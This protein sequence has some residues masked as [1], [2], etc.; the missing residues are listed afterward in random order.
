MPI[1]RKRTPKKDRLKKKSEEASRTESSNTPTKEE[2]GPDPTDDAPAEEADTPHSDTCMI[3]DPPKLEAT[4]K[5]RKVTKDPAPPKRT[6]RKATTATPEP[7]SPPETA[8]RTK[9]TSKKASPKK[10]KASPRKRSKPA[11]KSC[12]RHETTTA[13]D[14]DVEEESPAKSQMSNKYPSDELLPDEDGSD[15]DADKELTTNMNTT[16]TANPAGTIPPATFAFRQR[17]YAQ[18]TETAPLCYEGVVR[19][20]MYGVQ[21][22]RQLQLST[23]MTPEEIQNAL[24]HQDESEEKTWWYFIHYNGWNVKWDRWVEEQ[25]LYEVTESTKAFCDRLHKEVKA[26]RGNKNKSA[27]V[28]VEL[29]RRMVQLEADHRLTERKR[30]LAAA[31]SSG[32]NSSET[33]RLLM[34]EEQKEAA[35]LKS[36]SPSKRKNTDKWSKKAHLLKEMTLRRDHQMQG[37]RSQATSELLV[38]PFALKKILVEE[39]E[40]ICQCK[41]MLAILPAVV[42]VRQALMNYLDQKLEH[43]NASSSRAKKEEQEDTQKQGDNEA[44]KETISTID[45]VMSKPETSTSSSKK[46]NEDTQG[47]DEMKKEETSDPSENRPSALELCSSANPDTIKPNRKMSDQEREW[48]EMVDGVCLFFDQALPER[49]LYQS[50]KI[51]H[52]IL[53]EGITEEQ[54]NED[55]EN[56]KTAGKG[57]VVIKSNSDIYGCEFL[58]R[59]FLRLPSLL[60][61]ELSEQESKSILAKLNDLVRYLQ[62]Q[63]DAIFTQSYRRWNDVEL[64][65][66]K[67]EEE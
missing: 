61:G 55:D 65:R 59:M 52:Q 34:A 29:E 51:Q 12:I 4:K 1:T 11:S 25:H 33:A 17:V 64:L 21:H 14:I 22:Q 46:E 40:I 9:K 5:R 30:K 47:K 56:D 57:S 50:E 41:G 49:L 2:D 67:E 45:P 32:D 48:R 7:P 43:L 6:R 58:L 66:R 36:K 20:V 10:K 8:K 62:K 35:K 37:R 26:I 42:P 38:L 16:T 54:T 31:A 23:K 19:R 3:D 15:H 18:D 27:N 13:M 63:Q 60:V 39:W 28:T 24:T 53:T 44:K